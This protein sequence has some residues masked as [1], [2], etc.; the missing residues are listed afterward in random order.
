MFSALA[1][2]SRVS[3]SLR[4]RPSAR[5]LALRPGANS[6]RSRLCLRSEDVF[7]E[8]V[9]L[10]RGG[11]A[12]VSGLALLLHLDELEVQL[13]VR[14]LQRRELFVADELPGLIHVLRVRVLPVEEENELSLLV[15]NRDEVVVADEVSERG[16]RD[17]S[18][19]SL[20]DEVADGVAHARAGRSADGAARASELVEHLVHGLDLAGHEHARLAR[21]D[22]LGVEPDGV[23][24]DATSVLF[25]SG[26]LADV[27]HE[28]V[29]QSVTER[30]VVGTRAVARCDEE[31]LRQLEAGDLPAR[32][33]VEQTVVDL[34][35]APQELVEEDDVSLSELG[36]ERVVQELELLLGVV[37]GIDDRH[38]HALDLE[39]TEPADVDGVD[40]DA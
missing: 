8:L 33:D 13:E 34:G 37:V 22:T 9:V 10:L 38:L 18:E 3:R 39:R 25:R 15:L 17:L 5:Q 1:K 23:D 4:T 7:I 28:D 21:V 27:R 31:H 32:H 26:A 16:A 35:E 12:R 2:N 24:E 30:L 19:Q 6:N 40:L 36:P 14:G 20:P 11:G 29:E